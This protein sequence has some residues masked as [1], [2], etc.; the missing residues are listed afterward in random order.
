MTRLKYKLSIILFLMVNITLA[1]SN[2][3]KDAYQK[4]KVLFNKESKDTNF[5]I[6]SYNV[7]EGFRKDSSLIK[8]FQVWV[9]ERNPDV[10]GFQEMNGFSKEELTAFAEATGYPY[11]VLQKRVG[12]PIALI[13]KFPIS[14]VYK[15]TKGM[16]HGFVYAKILDYNIF[17]THLNPKSYL[18]RISETDTLLSY[19]NKIPKK[20]KIILMGDFNNMS[21]LDKMNYDNPDKMKRVINSE[22]NNPETK[23]LNNGAIDFTVTQK[24]LDAGLYDS[25]RLFNNNYEKSAP[26]KIRNHKN[27]TRIDYIWINEAVKNKSIDAT[28]VKDD[29]TDFAS[30]HYPMLLILKK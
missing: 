7:Y 15:V 17:V 9:K 14:N 12:F 18:E 8:R 11:N 10:V 6:L 20:E 5:K 24:L 22:K 19:I 27:Y 4:T 3:S 23:I 13:S 16:K 21:V 29:F 28:I 30:D 25:W 2:N 1:Q 26:T